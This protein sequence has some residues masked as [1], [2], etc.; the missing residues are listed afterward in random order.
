MIL[1][2][3]KILSGLEGVHKRF[4]ERV[5]YD[6]RFALMTLEGCFKVQT[7]VELFFHTVPLM[8]V[9]CLSNELTKW[10][11]IAKLMLIVLIVMLIKNLSLVTVFVIR[12]FIDNANDPEM[13]PRTNNV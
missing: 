5:G 12:R 10:T 11:S 3:M 6:E 9:L 7:I 1:Q 4:S 13:R 8:I 2:Q